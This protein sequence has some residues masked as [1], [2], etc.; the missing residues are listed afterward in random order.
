[1]YIKFRYLI[2]II[3][4]FFLSVNLLQAQDSSVDNTPL[5][6][7]TPEVLMQRGTQLAISLEEIYQRIVAL[8]QQSQEIN[9]QLEARAIERA[10]LELPKIPDAVDAKM[11][12]ETVQLALSAWE[13]RGQQLAALQTLLESQQLL[14]NKQ[15]ENMLKL[16][17]EYQ[18]VEQA[19][20]QSQP[21]MEELYKRWQ[22]KEIT[23]ENLPASMQDFLKKC[24]SPQKAAK[25]LPKPI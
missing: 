21:L 23:V 8:N 16:I 6:A 13:N 5:N 25:P 3:G 1:M 9:Q 22:A 7:L 15:R 12:A 2:A 10:S 14:A 24:K 17:A 18:L 20:Q 11:G 19:Q 4:L